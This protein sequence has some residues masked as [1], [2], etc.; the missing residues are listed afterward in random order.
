MK[1]KPSKEE[2]SGNFRSERA[3]DGEES[4]CADSTSKMWPR[5]LK[6]KLISQV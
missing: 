3:I 2:I 5:L 1:E 4:N 6:S